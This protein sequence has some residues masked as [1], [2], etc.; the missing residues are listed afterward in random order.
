MLRF[1]GMIALTL[2]GC[3]GVDDA[4]TGTSAIDKGEVHPGD[5]AVG[6]VLTRDPSIC[7]GTLIAP[8]VVLTAAHCVVKP[9]RGFFTGPGQALS[10]AKK[11]KKP[12]ANMVEH[13]VKDSAMTPD[14]ADTINAF[15]EGA[16]CPNTAGRDIGLVLLTTPIKGIKAVPFATTTGELP[17]AD[18]TCT[19]IGYGNH[20]IGKDA[21][22]G[23][24]R[25]AT[26]TMAEIV[27]N[28]EFNNL[29][30]VSLR[31][32]MKSGVTDG[33]DSG[34]PLFFRDTIVGTTSCGKAR[35]AE[36]AETTP[37]ETLSV[38]ASV[39]ASAAWIACTMRRFHGTATKDEC[40]AL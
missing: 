12:P 36:L 6:L 40:D 38:F 5:P 24:K 34:G 17:N 16:P 27:S 22:V 29:N 23:L 7:T 31:V 32:L 19:T 35:N 14:Y 4:A 18:D 39:P 9:P 3:G 10:A 11:N 30:A 20:G 2:S 13:L 21:T 37:T 1:F 8:D 26:V 28:D 25:S 15:P 33:G